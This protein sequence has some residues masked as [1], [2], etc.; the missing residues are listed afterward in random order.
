MKILNVMIVTAVTTFITACSNIPLS[1][2]YRMVNLNPLDID[3]RQLVVA[4]R[5]PQGVNVR[6]GDIVI[7]FSF[8]TEKPDISFK[9][10]FLVKTNPDY[11]ISEGMKED[12][13]E[14]EHITILQ[15]SAQDALT[16]HRAQQ[17]VKAYRENHDDG[18]GRFSINVNSVCRDN[19]FSEENSE[20]DINLKLKNEEEFFPF[21]EDID[22]MSLGDNKGTVNAI[23][24]CAKA[25]AENNDTKNSES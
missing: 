15:L 18:A 16:M 6:D 5:S 1:T 17:A 13:Q 8:E 19:D 25:N 24:Y 20:L 12:T 22:L 21:M 10:K 7:N 2:M 14:N 23:P 4:V 9:H 11:R 3:P